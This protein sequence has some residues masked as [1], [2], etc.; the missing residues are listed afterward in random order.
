MLLFLESD[1][2]GIIAFVEVFAGKRTYYAYIDAGA[3]F[4]ARFEEVKAKYPQ[5]VLT[6]GFREEPNWETYQLYRRL[7]PW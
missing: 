2:D 5:H 7:Y 6:S 4:K 1:G 3:T